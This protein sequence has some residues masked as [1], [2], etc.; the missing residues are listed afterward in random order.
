MP[1]QLEQG[2][3]FGRIGKSIGEGVG[4]QIGRERVASALK[5]IE[6]QQFNPLDLTQRLT[7]AGASSQEI[8]NYLPLIQQEQARKEAFPQAQLSD[9]NASPSTEV[10]GATQK[11]VSPT[12]LGKS[13]Q[14]LQGTTQALETRARELMTNQPSLY[15]DPL[16]AM[17]KAQSEY[18]NQQNILTKAETEFDKVLA[19]K[20]QKAGKDV[21]KD[22]IGDMQHNYLR[23]VQALA[24]S[25]K[26]SY[27]KAV[28]AET[29]KLMDFG[30]AKTALKGLTT[31]S[32]FGGEIKGEQGLK[33]LDAIRKEYK[34][35]DNLELFADD[36]VGQV[37]LSTPIANYLA[38]PVKSNQEINNFFQETRFKHKKTP[39][40][41]PLVQ[42]LKEKGSS[43]FMNRN[44]GIKRSEQ[45]IADF[46]SS[47]LSDSDSLNSIALTAQGR[48]YNAQK[49]IDSVQENWNSG[50]VRLNKRQQR[51]LETR[52]SFR[53]TLRDISYFAGNGLNPLQV[54]E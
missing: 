36:L 26:E 22:I 44:K 6:G 13:F 12:S 15:R 45:E 37:G 32:F 27:E 34:D 35:T 30:K 31:P 25:G 23:N 11:Q 54:T 52:G 42:G 40:A 19:K 3:I 2:D 9:I 39:L 5:P 21:D 33:K 29:T 16:K 14:P 1:A 8:S 24:A 48:G 4:E 53:P 28:D 20:L 51:E 41:G 46:V 7:R 47:H 18:T 10:P 17:E 38:F 49:I 43:S 50:K